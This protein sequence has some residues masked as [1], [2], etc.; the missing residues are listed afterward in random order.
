MF[1]CFDF[2]KMGA[3]DIFLSL[4]GLLFNAWG[5]GNGPRECLR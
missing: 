2:I 5:R 4:G 3:K 1:S